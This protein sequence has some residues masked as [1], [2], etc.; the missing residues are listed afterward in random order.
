L[1][2][3]IKYY[4]DQWKKLNINFLHD[5]KKAIRS[6]KKKNLNYNQHLYD[7]ILKDFNPIFVLSTGR[8]GTLFLSNILSV[9][10]MV[11]VFHKPSPEMYFYSKIAYQKF[12]TDPKLIEHVFAASRFEL[13]LESYKRNRLYVETNN[14]ITFFAYAINSIFSNALFIHLL[15]HPGDFVRSGIRRNWYTGTNKHDL[16][17]ILPEES[18]VDWINFSSIEKMSWLWNETNKFIENF[19]SSL[20]N[21]Q[22]II[23]VKSE[24]LF[25]SQDEVIRLLNFIGLSEI[26]NKKILKI[27]NNP[28]N[29][30][31]KGK[32]HPYQDWDDNEK[33]QLRRQIKINSIYKYPL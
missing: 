25:S 27:L 22:R 13:I 15:R 1:L 12:K 5:T 24:D 11:D 17:R 19:K 23:T 29:I 16:G 21:P 8:C 4:F 9:F 33:D 14:K 3:D 32:F 7:Q 31:K 2:K 18:S 6:G 30:Q 28:A 26:P 20:N 10:D